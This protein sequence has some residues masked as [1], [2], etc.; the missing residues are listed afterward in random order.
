MTTNT[1]AGKYAIKG[2]DDNETTCACCGRTDLKRAVQ[3]A[4]LDADGNE[5]AVEAY[6][7]TCAARLIAPK[8]AAGE[9]RSLTNLAKAHAFLAKYS[10]AGYGLD[11]ICSAVGVK[12]SV[13]A[14]VEDG[15][16]KFNTSTGWVAVK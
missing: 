4:I 13:W 9:S 7:T 11:A 16:V 12:F 3:L 5:G 6:G 10:A 1:T 8:R 2:L 14:V 15:V